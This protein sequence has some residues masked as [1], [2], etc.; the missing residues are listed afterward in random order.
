MYVLML[1]ALL[2]I[3]VPVEAGDGNRPVIT[4]AADEWCPHNC[5]PAADR[6][7]YMVELAREIFSAAGYRVEYRIMPWARTLKAVQQGEVTAAIGASPPELPGAIF[8]AETI[9][10]FQAHFIISSAQSWRYRG[11]RS[12]SGIRLGVINNYD[13]GV[14]N[15]WI[16]AHRDSESLLV[17]SGND[18]GYRGLGMLLRGRLDALLDDPDV[19]RYRA[20][21]LGARQQIS[22]AGAVGL[23]VDIYLAFSPEVADADHYARTFSEGIRRLRRSGRLAQLLNDYGLSDWK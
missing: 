14:F 18:A 9:G 7:G 11:T 5:Q 23:P 21:Q 19:A 12:L 3:P 22:S 16:S 10:R 8:P 2:L 20:S 17:L 1:I 13:Y 4:L 15:R 6:P